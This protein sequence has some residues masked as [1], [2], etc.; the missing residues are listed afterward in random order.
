MTRSTHHPAYVAF[1][2]MLREERQTSGFTQ[3]QLADRLGNRQTFISKLESGDRRLDII[4][5]FEYLDS[6]GSDP[7]DFV[8]RLRAKL[9]GVATR[10]NRKLAI[11]QARAK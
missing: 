5:L 2:K 7:V 6:I 4:E 8:S 1:L 9:R 3:V 11:R 10:K